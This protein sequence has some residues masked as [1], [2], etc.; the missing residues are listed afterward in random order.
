MLDHP[1][2][3]LLKKAASTLDLPYTQWPS[4]YDQLIAILDAT[5]ATGLEGT[6]RLTPAQR[7]EV[8]AMRDR[9]DEK[10]RADMAPVRGASVPP[11]P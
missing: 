6:T 10:K 7:D 5:A 9:L 2:S 8:R 3:S 11:G 4:Y 1:S